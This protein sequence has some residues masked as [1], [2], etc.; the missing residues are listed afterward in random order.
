MLIVV[1]LAALW[2]AAMSRYMGDDIWWAIMASAA[3]CWVVAVLNAQTFFGLVHLLLMAAVVM[4]VVRL[5]VL[6]DRRDGAQV[7]QPAEPP[8][9]TN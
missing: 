9:A 2:L 5:Q 8:G 3:T 6:R 4:L 1:I 7:G